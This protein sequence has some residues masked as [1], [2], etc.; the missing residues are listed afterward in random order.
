MAKRGRGNKLPVDVQERIIS[1]LATRNPQGDTRKHR[2]WLWSITDIAA[3]NDVDPKTV[4]KV[5]REWMHTY[6]AQIKSQRQLFKDDRV[7][8]G[9]IRDN[10]D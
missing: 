8:R 4:R 5:I 10:Q 9:N 7:K 6:W 1:M 3:E 2:K